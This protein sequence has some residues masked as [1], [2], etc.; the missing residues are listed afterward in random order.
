MR[1]GS[2][3]IYL[4]IF[5]IKIKMQKNTFFSGEPIVC[6]FWNIANKEPNNKGKRPVTFGR[7]LILKRQSHEIFDPRFYS[8]NG[9]PGSPDSWAKAVLNIDSN[10]RS[11]SIRFGA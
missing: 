3:R 9:T 6:F 11:N 1:C 5:L 10:W 2:G 4:Y 7:I 8:L